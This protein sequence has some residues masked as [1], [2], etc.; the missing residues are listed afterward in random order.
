MFVLL[1]IHVNI[2]THF[3]YMYVC[4]KTYI[5]IRCVLDSDLRVVLDHRIQGTC[6]L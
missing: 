1:Y 5:Y 6:H 3:I 4:K 2:Y